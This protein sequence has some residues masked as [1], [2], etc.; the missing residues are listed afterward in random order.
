MKTKK[1]KAKLTLNKKT[2]SNLDT[3]Q[4]SDLKGGIIGTYTGC[5]TA[6]AKCTWTCGDPCIRWTS[7]CSDNQIC[8]EQP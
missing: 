1:I 3:Q 5:T 2:I 7:L 6:A 8:I 4:M